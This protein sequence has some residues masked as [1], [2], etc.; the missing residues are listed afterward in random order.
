MMSLAHI[1]NPVRVNETSDLFIA[2][3]ITFSTMRTAK[4][5]SKDTLDVNLYAIQYQDEVRITLPDCFIRVPDLTRSVAD[6]KL[7]KKEKKLPLIGDILDSLYD[8][9]DT[10]YL[11]YTNVD[12]AL[13]PY[14][15]RSVSKIIEQGY[16]AFVINRRTIPEC[17]DNLDQ[18][19]LMVAEIG[20]SHSGYD[21]FVFK[22]EMYPRFKLGTICIGTAWIGRALLANMVT[23]AVK[24]MEFRNVHLTFHIG[25]SASWR[26]DEYSDY[27]REN[28]NEYLRV[29]NQLEAEHGEFE[30]VLR[31]YLLDT[32]DKRQFPPCVCF[33]SCNL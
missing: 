18:I 30:P 32:G 33:N 8:I 24:F 23:Y 28:Q 6:L 17:Y 1:I 15:Y 7:F 16:D 3:P 11:I 12:I 5:F 25:D 21:C 14:F 2:Q 19:P 10:D 22:R 29:F 4:E 27:F 9:A 26:H 13:Q 31:S 20:K